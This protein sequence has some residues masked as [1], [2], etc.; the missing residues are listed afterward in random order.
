MS[1]LIC[2]IDSG[3][4]LNRMKEKS[5]FVLDNQLADY[6]GL[7]PQAISNIRRRNSI[8]ISN[9]MLYA[10]KSGVSLEYI[11][12]G[13]DDYI[14]P[15][16]LD[17]TSVSES[18]IRINKKWF[19]ATFNV[20]AS[21]LFYYIDDNNYYLLIDTSEKGHS[22]SDGRFLF[23]INSEHIV[24][25]CR[26]SVLGLVTIEGEACPL[27]IAEFNNLDVVGKVI[28]QLSAP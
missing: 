25:S 11:I 13:T 16:H 1:K 10:D 27:D 28:Y 20:P 17:N 5:N 15:Q 4:L 9:I 19:K 3:A 14:I 21:D 23:I 24:R 22:A 18:P 2:K 12:Y 26:L 6:L 8:E 7:K